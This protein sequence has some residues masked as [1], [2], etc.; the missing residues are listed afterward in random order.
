MNKQKNILLATILAIAFVMSMFVVLSTISAAD[1]TENLTWNPLG[2]TTNYTNHTGSFLFN[3]TTGIFRVHNVTV[4]TNSSAGVMTALQTFTNTTGNQTAWSGT[5]T[6]TA[7]N[8]G[9]LQNISCH[10][11]NGTVVAAA[12]TQENL[13]KNV[14]LDTTDPVCNISRV[15]STFAWKGTQEL[16]WDSSDAIERVS[17]LVTIDRPGLGAD[18]TY[19]DADR[20]LTLTSQDTKY[21]GSW[22]ATVLATDRAGNTDTDSVTFKSYMPD[23]AIDEGYLPVP[24]DNGKALL[25]IL[26]V[27]AI[28]YFVFKKK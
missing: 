13:G 22:T 17:T 8:D 21:T 28:L 20:I 6:I 12:Y 19:S 10:P 24:K 3:C 16:T 26:V 18:L 1:L 4:Y 15:H 11:D 25:L 14:M 27:A 7:T 5:V 9:T 23:G 2:G